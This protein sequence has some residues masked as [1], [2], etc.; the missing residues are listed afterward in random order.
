MIIVVVGPTGVGKTKLSIELAKKLN[1]EIINADSTQVYRGLDI[2]TAKI[3]DQEGIKHH[4]IDIKDVDDEYSVYDFQKD[5]RHIIDTLLS[6]KKTPIIVGGTGLYIKALLY[7]YEFKEEKSINNYEHLSNE[8]LYNKLIKVDKNTTI[9]PNNRKRIIRALNYY[10]LY[11]EP[12]SN[13]QKTN[14]KIYDFIL[15]GLTTERDNLY[16][17]IN[18]RA[19][20]MMNNGLIEE[21][22]KIYDSN[23][24]SKA[25]MTPI[26]YKEL[27][28]YFEGIIS[29]EEAISNIQQSSRKY[30]KRQYTWFNNQMEVKWFNVNYNCFDET[31]NE[32]LNYIKKA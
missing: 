22:K 3:K 16:K 19:V 4:L 1:G 28:P 24:R 20:S 6:E 7:N 11:Q 27:F 21:A 25:I 14:Q 15:I 2:A 17:I 9:H 26:G 30:S 13:K 12:F 5:G 31:V 23:I 18:D 8:E 32:V 29:K 10:D